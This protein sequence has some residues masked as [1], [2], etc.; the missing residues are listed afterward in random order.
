MRLASLALPEWYFR[1][2][3]GELTSS[4]LVPAAG[5]KTAASTQA[6]SLMLP[7]TCRRSAA[8]AG[9]C[10]AAVVWRTSRSMDQ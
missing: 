9:S 1:K 3:A 5:E 10:S 7:R 6:L 8:N 4:G 2:P